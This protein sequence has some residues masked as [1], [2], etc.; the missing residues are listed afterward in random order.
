MK[1][2]VLDMEGRHVARS[3]WWIYRKRRLPLESLELEIS[4]SESGDLHV[5]AT[6]RLKGKVAGL[7]PG[8]QDVE[9]ELELEG[10]MYRIAMSTVFDVETL[11]SGEC[12]VQ[13]TGILEAIG[14]EKGEKPGGEP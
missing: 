10:V 13:L 5:H 7:N 12:N 1:Q 11:P 14:E 8:D 4:T 2:P 9:F 6:G 3:A